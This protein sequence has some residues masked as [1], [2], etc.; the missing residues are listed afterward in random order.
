MIIKKTSTSF[1]ILNPYQQTLFVVW[2]NLALWIIFSIYI[3]QWWL[4][5]LT[6][7]A[8]QVFCVISE[9]ST[10]RYY[11]HKSYKTTPFREKIL[12]FFSLL[13]GQGAILS[14][15]TLHRTHHLYEDGPEDPHSPLHIPW[16]LVFFGL[17]SNNYKKNL[18]TDLLRSSGKD[19][20][21]WENKYYWL[22]WIGLWT[23]TFFIN[24]WIFYFL[25]AG[26]AS[27]YLAMSSINVLNHLEIVGKKDHENTVSTNSFMMHILMGNGYHNNHHNSPNSY[28]IGDEKRFDLVAWFISNFFD[29]SLN[30]S[31]F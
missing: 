23:G 1:F 8:L 14:W 30:R 18:V 11:S 9:S 5:P 13:S 21:I 28:N 24:F 27:W 22:L 10:H 4:I 3:H 29:R 31:S 17:Y 25:I 15:S 7:L 16:Y 19:Y 6:Y 20:Y 2:G 12:R 26:A